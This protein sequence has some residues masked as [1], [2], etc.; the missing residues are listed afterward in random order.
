M[1]TRDGTIFAGKKEPDQDMTGGLY[2]QGDAAADS[3]SMV[4]MLIMSIRWM[5]ICTTW[6]IRLNSQSVAVMRPVSNYSDHMF[7]LVLARTALQSA[8]RI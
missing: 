7:Y 1:L 8:V 2:T 6:Q 4:Q 3:I 5:H